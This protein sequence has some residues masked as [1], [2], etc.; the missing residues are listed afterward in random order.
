MAPP[1]EASLQMGKAGCKEKPAA[2]DMDS[3]YSCAGTHGRRGSVAERS[4]EGLGSWGWG[5][6]RPWLSFTPDKCAEHLAGQCKCWHSE[7]PLWRVRFRASGAWIFF[8]WGSQI[9]GLLWLCFPSL[10]QCWPPRLMF[11]LFAPGLT[12]NSAQKGPPNESRDNC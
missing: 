1:V 8:H 4:L 3:Q 12:E 5:R 10:W 7:F 11:L 9:P 2:C 6:G